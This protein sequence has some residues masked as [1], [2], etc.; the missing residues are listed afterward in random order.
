MIT[1][2][3]SQERGHARHGWLESHHTFSFAG[4]HDPQHMGFRD[5]RVINE[6]RV[7]PR[8]GFGST[9]TATWRS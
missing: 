6:D 1:V 9:R 3:K 5:L 8:R 2:R 7:Q 4:Y